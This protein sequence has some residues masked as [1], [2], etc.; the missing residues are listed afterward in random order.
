MIFSSLIIRPKVETLETMIDNKKR[1]NLILMLLKNSDKIF[2]E[3]KAK[4]SIIK[5][6]EPSNITEQ[7]K[8][9]NKYKIT[10]KNII[11]SIATDLNK[12]NNDIENATKVET[13]TKIAHMLK[14]MKDLFSNYH[15]DQLNEQLN[16]NNSN[17]YVP[18]YISTTLL[19]SG[20]SSLIG[21][22][23][24]LEDRVSL[25]DDMNEFYN[26]ILSKEENRSFYA[27][28]D[29]HSGQEAAELASVYVPLCIAN[30][31]GVNKLNNIDAI[32]EGIKKADELICKE[33]LESGFNS[34]TTLVMAMII[35]ETLYIAN[36]GDS[37][38]VI[39]KRKK[40]NSLHNEFDA[41]VLSEI[42]KPTDE[43]EKERITSLGGI[44]FRGRILG[45]LAVSRALGD[46]EYK[47]P[48]AKANF[49]SN[50]P[51]VYS[52]DIDEEYDFIILACDGLWDKVSYIEAVNFVNDQR[53]KGLSAN[54]ISMLLC[55][56]ALEKGSKDNVTVIVVILKW[57][58]VQNV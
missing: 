58:P 3:N 53:E 11:R 18:Q 30:E 46:I 24:E 45:K 10:L 28:Y 7:K 47:I 50:T 15:E 29:G 17:D 48:S 22:R 44:V 8:T 56:Y 49:V 19:E 38:I 43:K 26:N 41:I 35:N 40:T 33:A 6:Y 32:I 54:E 55:K 16:S 36:L 25:F 37:E 52:L 5:K 34:G 27:V 9:L 2:P 31:I 14:V 23:P 20:H 21:P 12:L 57:R 39:A 13:V 51:Y 42:H 1:C 4:R